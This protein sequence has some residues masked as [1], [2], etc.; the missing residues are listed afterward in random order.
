[1]ETSNKKKSFSKLAIKILLPLAALLITFLIVINITLSGVSKTESNMA[2]LANENLPGLTIAQELRY[3]VLHTS[4]FFTDVSAVKALDEIN[5]GEEIKEAV[6]EQFTLL[7]QVDPSNISFYSGVES[8]YDAFYELCYKMALAYITVGTDAGN[9]VMDQVDPYTDKL[10]DEMDSI[11]E[12]MKETMNQSVQVTAAS[13]ST[14]KSVLTVSAAFIILLI[15]VT[16]F[17]VFKVVIAPV[18]VVTEALTKLAAQDLT[19]EKL[20][21]KSN[22]EMGKLA[23]N[24][25]MLLESTREVIGDINDSAV[26]VDE[27]ATSVKTNSD[28]I[29][30]N[31]SAIA[32]AVSNIAQGANDQAMEIEKTGEEIDS[33]KAIIETNETVAGNLSAACEKISEASQEGTKIINDLYNVT[34]QSEIAFE[35]IFASIGYI[36]ESSEKIKQ[37]SGLIESISSQ[38]NLLS[39]NASIEAA[40][41]GDAG[42]GFAVVADEIRSLSDE[43]KN[44]VLEI[45]AMIENLQSKVDLA[46][47]KSENIKITVDKQVKSVE[48][49]KNKYADITGGVD[50]I[51]SEIAELGSVSTS[52]T[53]SVQNVTEIMHSVAAAA[54]ESTASTEETNAS[55]EE[56]LAMVEEIA[57]ECSEI[58]KITVVLNENV[59]KYTL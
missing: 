15:V 8:D 30:T 37:A 7:R 10:S 58:K 11:A 3:Q 47:E 52:L 4:E 23:E 53:A 44:C 13:N 18:K 42:R 40:R 24:F 38:T 59:A 33:L 5:D 45:N 48:E 20:K 6:K 28:S 39:L 46:S 31:M 41:A 35:D 57:E 56:V 54:E 32:E 29:Q 14:V 50:S 27:T 2:M 19:I 12:K 36:K 55:V 16:V 17:I 22:D 34:K 51:N 1:M 9:E 21:V 26:S 25:N 49:T 43:T